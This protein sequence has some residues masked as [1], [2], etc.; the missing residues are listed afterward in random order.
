MSLY[1]WI[2]RVVY[3]VTWGTIG[4]AIVLSGVA[5]GLHLNA[6][7]YKA[8]HIE[9]CDLAWMLASSPADTMV[10]DGIFECDPPKDTI[11]AWWRQDMIQQRHD[12]QVERIFEKHNR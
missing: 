2:D 5:L 4:I 3:Y 7:D 6:K 9:R 8:E 1:G 11:I 10:L 12:A